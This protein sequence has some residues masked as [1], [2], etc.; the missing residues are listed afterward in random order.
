MLNKTTKCL[1]ENDKMGKTKKH[2][3]KK[4]ILEEENSSMI[5]VVTWY[6]GL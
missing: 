1:G 3:Q 6:L 2:P 5:H 4:M